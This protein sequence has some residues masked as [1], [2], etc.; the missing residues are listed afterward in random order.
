MPT[1]VFEKIACQSIDVTGGVVRGNAVKVKNITASESLSV[2]DSGAVCHVNVAANADASVTLPEIT[3]NNLGICYEFILGTANTGALKILTATND[4]TT[5]DIFV[6]SLLNITNVAN[7]TVTNGVM[8]VVPGGDDCA[9]NLDENLTN[10]S[11]Q[12]GSYVK[13]TAFSYSADAHSTWMV[14]GYVINDAAASTGA[15]IFSDIDA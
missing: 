6:G 10:C 13:C 7:G 1:T 2:L 12:V 8:A 4:D 11:A 3:E 5:G 9:I 15:A 14:N